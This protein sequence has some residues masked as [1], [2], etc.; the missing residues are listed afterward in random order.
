MSC[1]LM[2]QG[3]IG[4]IEKKVS[5][6]GTTITRITVA[7]SNGDKDKNTGEYKTEWTTLTAFG[8]RADYIYENAYKGDL[9]N[10]LAKKSTNVRKGENEGDKNRYYVEFLIESYQLLSK[11]NKRN[12]ANGENKLKQD[13]GIQE[14]IPQ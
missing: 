3:R 4:K 10:I 6:N 5:A 7:A 13:G 9:V 1:M 14:E 11:S 12:D 2:V 8:A